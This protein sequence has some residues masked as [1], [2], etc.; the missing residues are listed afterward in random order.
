MTSLELSSAG[1]AQPTEA[2]PP[3]RRAGLARSLAPSALVT[4]S[5]AAA[6]AVGT[7]AGLW[8]LPFAAGLVI[9]VWGRRRPALRTLATAALAAAAGW[10]LVLLWSYA[11]G[12]DIGGTARTVAAL[13]G[14]PPPPSLML[15]ATLL[16]AAVQAAAG[17]T[18]GRTASRA[19]G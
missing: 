1:T 6:T 7:A 8:Y 13:I 10:A 2:A 19:V 16:L 3:A 5:G 4:L 14:L 9:G 12:A 15:L 18:L 17:C 11:Q